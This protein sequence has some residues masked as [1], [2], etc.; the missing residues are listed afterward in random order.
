MTPG[1]DPFLH[2]QMQHDIWAT[3][4]LMQRCRKLTRDQLELTVPGTFGTIRRTLAHIVAADERYL[5]RLLGVWDEEPLREA[6]DVALDTIAQHLPH[7]RDG[8]ERLFSGATLDP[9]R[10]LADTPLRRFAPN[11]ARFEMEVWVPAAQ[12][13][14]HG[15]D[16][17]THVNT[18]LGA[19]GLE[20]V[21]V[22]VWPYAIE[23]NA[24][25]EA[26]P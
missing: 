1:P 9:E 16:H 3:E 21:D 15:T 26:K 24:S 23:L 11:S 8:V 14:N 4:R 17:R 22:Q 25:H 2:R 12:L 5:A 19:N 20:T 6:P 18:I 13:I 7:V 10:V